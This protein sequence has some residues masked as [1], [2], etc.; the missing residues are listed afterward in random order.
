MLVA[1]LA[2]PAAGFAQEAVLTGT[3]TDSTGGVLPGVTVRAVNEAN[4]YTFDGVTDERG[5]FRIPARIGSYQITTELAG[6]TT[7]TRGGV[8][9]LVGQTAEVRHTDDAVSAA[10]IGHRDR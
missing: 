8:Q 5:F 6:F 3:V 7:V 10:G 1:I 9:L 2:I 4:G